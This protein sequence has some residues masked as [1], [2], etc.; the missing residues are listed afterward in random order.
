MPKADLDRSWTHKG[1]IYGPGTN[2]EIPQTL[3]SILARNGHLD[4]TQPQ[5]PGADDTKGD[6][7]STREMALKGAQFRVDSPGAHEDAHES[8]FEG[9]TDAQARNLHAGGYARLED[10]QAA[11]ID[12]LKQVKGIGEATAKKIKARTDTW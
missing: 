2:V 11:S 5:P 7:L 12:D 6:D 9:L 4:S 10:L 3:H 8:P 1:R